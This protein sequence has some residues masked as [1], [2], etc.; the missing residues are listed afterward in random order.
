MNE[1]ANPK[2]VLIGIFIATSGALIAGIIL[3]HYEGCLPSTNGHENTTISGNLITCTA[4][5]NN[6][7]RITING[8][9]SNTLVL[10][11]HSFYSDEQISY[12]SAGY[13]YNGLNCWE[14]PTNCPSTTYE[15][16]GRNYSITIP[17]TRFVPL[18]R[19]NRNR[20]FYLN[21]S[22]TT[23]WQIRGACQRVESNDGNHTIDPL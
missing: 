7:I 17:R 18:V 2:N 1:E 9:I 8:N 4:T 10:N 15:G 23:N 20:V 21:I 13:Y 16:D 22:P 19:T 11:G 14:E 3:I 5:S 6:H 12:V